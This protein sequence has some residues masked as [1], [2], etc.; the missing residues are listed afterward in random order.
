MS[1]AFVG[2]APF[3]GARVDPLGE[4]GPVDG[5]DGVT[6]G[7]T[8]KGR[9]LEDGGGMV[10]PVHGTQ[11]RSERRVGYGKASTRRSG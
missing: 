11:R 4:E 2:F 3:D 6:D 10:G 8:F 7:V 1:E 9:A 5:R